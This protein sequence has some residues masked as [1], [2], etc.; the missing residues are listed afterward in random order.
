[1][2]KGEVVIRCFRW[3]GKGKKL[4]VKGRDGVIEEWWIGKR[5][6]KVERGKMVALWRAG[7]YVVVG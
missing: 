7:G 1:M 5:V 4:K 6:S 3:G 2:V